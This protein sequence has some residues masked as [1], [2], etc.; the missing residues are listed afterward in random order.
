M[1]ILNHTKESSQKKYDLMTKYERE[2]NLERDIN[3]CL[4]SIFLLSQNLPL[5]NISDFFSGENFSLMESYEEFEISYELIKY[6]FHKQ[7]MISLRTGLE[8]GLFSIYWSIIG[9]D[10]PEFKKW[11]SSNHDTPFKNKKFWKTLTSNPNINNFNDKYNLFDEIK[12]FG[13]SDYVHTKGLNFSNFG[14]YQQQL[15]GKGDL[16]IFSDWAKNFKQITK[17]LEILHLLQFPTMNLRYS[18]EYLLSKFGTINRIPQ[19]GGGFGDGMDKI[20]RLIPDEQKRY[21]EELAREDDEVKYVIKWL[22]ELPILSEIEID[23][24]IIQ[25]QKNNIEMSGFDIWEKNIR[26][27]NNRITNKILK[28]LRDWAQSNNLM[29]REQIIKNRMMPRASKT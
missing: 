23:N 28:L 2:N 7:A 9:K 6:G 20:G 18:T 22:D 10:S 12:S 19:F 1:R 17:T 26:L 29:N 15:K 27:H 14:R 16:V 4:E 3:L 11:I 24:L 5:R 21:I 8:I 25:E 13:L